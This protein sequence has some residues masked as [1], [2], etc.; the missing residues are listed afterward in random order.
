[1]YKRP[2][3]SAGTS[4]ICNQSQNAF[5]YYNILLIG[6]VGIWNEIS[7]VYEIEQKT[8]NPQ[9]KKQEK[10]PTIL[11]SFVNFVKLM[12]TFIGLLTSLIC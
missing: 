10:K 8:M 7:V 2:N 4:L 1:M 5:K 11:L 3:L 6:V 12:V 9:L